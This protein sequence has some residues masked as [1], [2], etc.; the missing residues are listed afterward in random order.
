MKS[1]VIDLAA[2]S[3]MWL[4]LSR[5]EV[6]DAHISGT[7]GAVTVTRRNGWRLKKA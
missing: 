5:V 3:I 6:S 7:S 2:D 1:N 4:P